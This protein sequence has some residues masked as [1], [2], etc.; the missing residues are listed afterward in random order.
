MVRRDRRRNENKASFEMKI[1]EDL[2]MA[3]VISLGMLGLK[4]WGRN[5]E[6]QQKVVYNVAN[7]SIIIYRTSLSQTS[8]KLVFTSEY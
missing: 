5:M 1:E 2:D 3:G 4:S 8:S 7:K 6:G